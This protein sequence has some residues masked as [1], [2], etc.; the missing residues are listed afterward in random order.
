MFFFACDMKGKI[1]PNKTIKNV[2]GLVEGE[3]FLQVKK[4]LNFFACSLEEG[5]IFQN[6]RKIKS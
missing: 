4:L 1:K 6:N 2:L 5:N 3:I